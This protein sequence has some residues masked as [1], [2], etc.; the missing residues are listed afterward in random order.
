MPFESNPA[1]GRRP[2]RRFRPISLTVTALVFTSLVLS[3][4]SSFERPEATRDTR[5]VVTPSP[6]AGRSTSVPV[7]GGGTTAD[8]I[9]SADAGP[10]VEA[11]WGQVA[12]LGNGVEATIADSKRLEVKAETPGE[13]SGPAVAL[14]V[15][16]TNKSQGSID[17]GS[18]IVTL[19]DQAGVLG[20]PTTSS[21]FKPFTGSVAPGKSAAAVLVFLVPRSDAGP[22]KL[23]VTYAAGQPTAL[24]SGTI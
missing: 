5:P 20:Q 15:E 6:S 16:L 14:T 12:D 8:V 22:F 19:T 4:C 18:P 23:S 9:Q 21:P 11:T 2:S 24:F 10:V 17:V 3:G 13:T 1:G 7:A